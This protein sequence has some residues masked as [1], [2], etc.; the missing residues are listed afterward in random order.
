MVKVCP[1]NVA[2]LSHDSDIDAAYGFP[3]SNFQKHAIEAILTGNHVLITAHT[4]SGKTL[5]AEF[6][7]EHF[8]REGRKVIYTS[9]IKALS[10]QKYHEFSAKYPHISFGILTGDIKFNPE[11]DV[12]IMTTEI[13][14]NHVFQSAAGGEEAGSALGFSIDVERELGCVI[15]DE[16]HYINDKDRGRV[17]EEA[18]LNMPQGS[19]MVML[20][21][22]IDQPEKFAEWV[23][24][25]G[26]G[27]TVYLA[28][29]PHRVVPLHHSGFLTYHEG[30]V[31]KIKDDAVRGLFERCCGQPRR[32]VSGGKFA[33]EEYFRLQRVKAHAR[34]LDLRTKRSFVLHSLVEHL[35]TR[36]MLPA[37]T[38]I[39]SRS[40][41]ERAAAEI[42]T[43]LHEAESDMPRLV[44]A[45]C[46]RIMRRL[47]NRE[48]YTSLA[49]YRQIVGLLRKGIAFHHAGMLPVFRE[50]V[51]LLFSGSYIKLLVA[52]ETFAVG[53]NM[54]A[55]TVVFTSLRKFD[56]TDTRALH[57]H[58]YT[59][60]AGRAGRRGIDTEGHVIHCNNL[61]EDV[62]SSEYR[63]ML[64]GSPQKIV[65]KF[66]ISHDLVLN[67]I[68]CDH[69]TDESLEQFTERSLMRLEIDEH[70]KGIRREVLA[71]EEKA[72]GQEDKI[73]AMRT[74]VDICR[75]YVALQGSS[76]SSRERKKA[77]RR[78]AEIEDAYRSLGSDV[79]L[80]REL[81]ATRDAI[82]NETTAL[83]DV[84]LYVRNQVSAVADILHDMGLVV[85]TEDGYALSGSGMVAAR[86]QEIPGHVLS[87]LLAR[88]NYLDA[89]EPK[90]I[91]S[92]FS[93]FTN[94]AVKEG[95]PPPQGPCGD[96][97]A[98]LRTI[99]DEYC[100]A[101]NARGAHVAWERGTHTCIMDEVSRW[102]DASD[103][104]E[105][106]AV[107]SSLADR[108]VFLGEFIKGM[109]KIDSVACELAQ[110]PGLPAS[111]QHKLT[112][113]HGLV[114]KHVVTNQSL[115]V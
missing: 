1:D 67:L 8:H 114:Q 99:I 19:Q 112:A 53:I 32:L 27:K 44:E 52:T 113:I 4:G 95:A 31:R 2:P 12:L 30:S 50:M 105:C 91:A 106:R 29:T 14:R 68:A 81:S 75:E 11:A 5:P 98:S 24:A 87:G 60:M 7:I 58:E 108:G 21:A 79:A 100:D 78:K 109:L 56:G 66:N 10:N 45:E 72:R 62:E 22:T 42:T 71:L 38:F 76:R 55:R 28:S 6:A 25:R 83:A 43:S 35:R 69:A 80:V 96:M 46:E 40:Q 47:P 90:H 77:G 39:F 13:L 88:H 93:C 59:Q 34:K 82:K 26:D 101:E 61:F 49:E 85:R 37:I 65:S 9:P 111:L 73:S 23:E 110:L 64:C 17:W 86:V 51:E 74:P 20:S 48:E 70:A 57:P 41:V 33:E 92:V 63:R 3:L 97:V 104:G 15:F 102:C 103:E 18:I 89:L 115:Y 94:V 107:T 84:E 16:V 54:P 36:D